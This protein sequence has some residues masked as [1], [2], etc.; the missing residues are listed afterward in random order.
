MLEYIAKTNGTAGG[1]SYPMLQ[2]QKKR[3]VPK[4]AGG[5]S[6]A[7]A[8]YGGDRGEA[9]AG[10]ARQTGILARGHSAPGRPGRSKRRVP[11]QCGGRGDAMASGGSGGTD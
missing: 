8:S 5:V 7:Q 2:H 11:H 4:K 6:E 9:K 3:G 1:E 10:P